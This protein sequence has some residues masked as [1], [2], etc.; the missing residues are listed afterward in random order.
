MGIFIFVL[1]ACKNSYTSEE[2]ENNDNENYQ[3]TCCEN[4]RTKHV[5]E[6]IQFTPSDNINDS[7]YYLKPDS[8]MRMAYIPEGI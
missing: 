5:L 8:S 4:S 2:S 6:E 7:L 1:S 3:K